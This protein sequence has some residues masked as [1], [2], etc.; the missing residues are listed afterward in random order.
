[1]QPW[2]DLN[3]PGPP[4]SSQKA[5]VLLNLR[6]PPPPVCQD[7]LIGLIVP[8]LDSYLKTSPKAREREREPIRVYEGA[9]NRL[10][11]RLGERP[12]AYK[13]SC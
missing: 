2:S 9:L 6:S 11:N 3:Y 1:M 13:P 5:V 4:S 7:G 8:E 10:T 12:I